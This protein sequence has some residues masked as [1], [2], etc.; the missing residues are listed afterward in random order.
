VGVS[1]FEV[2]AYCHWLA[3][4]LGKPIRLPTEEE[5]ERA[6]RHTDGRKYPWGE[7][8][9]RRR[10]NCAE[11]WGGRDDLDWDTWFKEKG[12]ETASTTI[13][14]QF[15]EG[16][17]QAGLSDMSGNVREWT[18]SWYDAE[19]VYRTVRGGSWFDFG[20]DARCACRDRDIPVGFP[21]HI[22]FRVLSPGATEEFVGWVSTD[23]SHSG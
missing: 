19:N 13:V 1:W 3:Q 12:Y 15:A 2:E 11:F 8:F 20:W 10:L 4:K 7:K 5:W 6:A 14:G 9:D 21:H 16:N 18:K 22:G 17:S 23:A